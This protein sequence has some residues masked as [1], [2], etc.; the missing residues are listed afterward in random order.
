MRGFEDT[1]LLA[2]HVNEFDTSQSDIGSGFGLEAEHRLDSTFDAAIILAAV[3]LG[4]CWYMSLLALGFAQWPTDS[5]T[6]YWTMSLYKLSFYVGIP[7]VV[8]G[9]IA[10][11]VP[12]MKWTCLGKVERHFLI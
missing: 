2:H 11:I 7:F 6:R 5:G 1:L 9:P 8:L 4:F 12:Y 10:A 3:V